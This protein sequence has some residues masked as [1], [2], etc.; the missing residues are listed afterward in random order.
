ML[1]VVL[2]ALAA[3]VVPTPAVAAPSCTSPSHSVNGE[4]SG[5]MKGTY[6]LKVAPYSDCGTIRSVPKGTEIFYH[7]LYVN[8]Y[9]NLW[10]YGRV[11]GTSTSGWMSLDNL[12]DTWLDD[13]GD[14]VYEEAFC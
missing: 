12:T 9:G 2:A 13:D 5:V 1:A 11:E 6:N 7:C 14:G 10:V 4:G 3:L 8:D